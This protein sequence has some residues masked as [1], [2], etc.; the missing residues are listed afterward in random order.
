MM[1]IGICAA[2]LAF[3]ADLSLLS[4]NWATSAENC[5]IW[6]GPGFETMAAE[7][8]KIMNISGN[9]MRWSRGSCELTEKKIQRNWI[10]GNASCEYRDKSESG[11][12]SVNIETKNKIRIVN[13]LSGYFTNGGATFFVNCDCLPLSPDDYLGCH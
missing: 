13:V 4:G 8:G 10:S 12:I 2:N 9:S 7:S 1:A 5:A 3:C 6:K 11:I